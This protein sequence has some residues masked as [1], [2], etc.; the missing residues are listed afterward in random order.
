MKETG[1]SNNLQKLAVNVESC[2]VIHSVIFQQ[3]SRVWEQTRQKIDLACCSKHS[4]TTNP[5]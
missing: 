5:H 3:R 1:I 4:H 2:L